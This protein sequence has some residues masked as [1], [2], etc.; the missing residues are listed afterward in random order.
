M[1]TPFGHTNVP[2]AIVGMACRLPGADNLEQFWNL[3]VSGGSS[4]AELPH[5]RL[6]QELYYVPRRGQR[7]KTYS[8]NGAIIS[9]REFD[10]QACPIPKSLERSVDNAHLLMCQTAAEALRH[11]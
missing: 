10:S 3:L 5:D 11:A 8:K 9:T 4:V 7:G 2:I 1:E 6:D